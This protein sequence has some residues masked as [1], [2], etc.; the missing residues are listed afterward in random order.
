[1]QSHLVCL[2][3]CVSVCLHG[4][5]VSRDS[6]EKNRERIKGTHQVEGKSKESDG[7]IGGLAKPKHTHTPKHSLGSRIVLKGIIRTRVVWL[8]ARCE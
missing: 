4:K 7:G 2:G 1:M 6:R 3:G 8:L 5:H